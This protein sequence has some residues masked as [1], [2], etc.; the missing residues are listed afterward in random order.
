[1]SENTQHLVYSLPRLECPV[2]AFKTL[3]L[4][5]AEWVE[6]HQQKKTALHLMFATVFTTPGTISIIS[7][8]AWSI[9]SP[10]CTCLNHNAITFSHFAVYATVWWMHCYHTALNRLIM[11]SRNKIS[12]Q[13]L[14]SSA[15]Y[16]QGFCRIVTMI[17]HWLCLALK[18]L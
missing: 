10:L 11:I 17:L 13:T 3:S 7:L 18:P 14:T 16:M 12:F 15:Y 5:P 9:Q 6:G 2:V 8:Y 1:M 4:T